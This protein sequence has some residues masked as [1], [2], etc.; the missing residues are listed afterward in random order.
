M[1]LLRT[2][3]ALTNFSRGLL[4]FG[5]LI[6]CRAADGNRISITLS[7]PSHG[8]IQDNDISSGGVRGITLL[9]SDSFHVLNNRIDG[10]DTG[11]RTDRG[12]DN[13]IRNNTITHSRFGVLTRRE[14]VARVQ[15][16][17]IDAL[18]FG[19]SVFNATGVRIQDNVFRS[20]PLADISFSRSCGNTVIAG[21]YLPSVDDPDACNRLLGKFKL[22]DNP[23]VPDDVKAMLEDLWEELNDLVM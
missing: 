10:Q 6:S 13:L 5:G 7:T 1:A 15:S 23:N 3:V 16:N 9:G 22:L 21:R 20:S 18:I 19:I 17:D 2:P 14:Q 11:V 12:R 8:M 4:L